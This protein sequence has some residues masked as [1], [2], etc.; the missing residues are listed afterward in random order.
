MSSTAITLKQLAEQDE[1]ASQRRL[2]LAILL[3]QDLA[4]IPFYSIREDHAANHSRC[5]R[6]ANSQ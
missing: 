6:C 5:M 4:T 1:I 2:V 3:F